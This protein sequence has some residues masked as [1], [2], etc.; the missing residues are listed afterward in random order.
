[1]QKLW[2]R[3]KASKLALDTKRLLW[4]VF[5]LLFLGSLRPSEAL[6]TKKGEY[7]GVKTLTWADIKILSACIEGKEVKFLQLTLKQPKT[8]KSMPTQLV[9]IPELGKHICAVKAIEKWIAGRKCR[10]D[11][12]TPVFTMANG[13]LVTTTYVNSIQESLL[14]EERPRV[15]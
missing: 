10:Q 13:D 8:A 5:T 1:M 7:D 2:T 12:A 9:E 3:L 4:A 11:P 14:K 6:S 15:T